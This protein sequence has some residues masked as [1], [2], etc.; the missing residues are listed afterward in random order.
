MSNPTVGQFRA[1]WQGILDRL[2]GQAGKAQVQDA[3]VK[4][5]IDALRQVDFST[6][7]GQD[8]I[9]AA[10]DLVKLNTDSIKN[11]DFATDTTLAQVKSELE[12]VKAELQAVK[13]N[14]VSGD[15]K[16][17]LSGNDVVIGLLADRPPAS[18]MRGRGYYAWDETD[19]H[20]L[21]YSDGTDWVVNQ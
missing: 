13:A 21:K 1:I 10:L 7:A 20:K 14:Q 4:D 17:Q 16:V 2:S 18:E 15:Q 8:A 12:A 11:K 9:K 6:E 3:D 19:G 5:A